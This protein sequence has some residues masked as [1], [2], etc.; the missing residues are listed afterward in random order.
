MIGGR[1]IQE[2]RT[3]NKQNSLYTPKKNENIALI[4]DT[5]GNVIGSW[6]V[7]PIKE[8]EPS[9]LRNASGDE[10]LTYLYDG[11]GI[12]TGFTNAA[13]KYFY[14]GRNVQGDI[15]E[16]YGEDSTLACRYE[17]ASWGKGSRRIR[18]FKPFF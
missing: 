17:Y 1:I 8:N 2:R 18:Y 7:A 15:I 9:R 16:I 4:R 10:T 3:A 13:G 5:K 12:L 11:S 6:D 14:Y